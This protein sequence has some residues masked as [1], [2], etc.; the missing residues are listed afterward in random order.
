MWRSWARART[1]IT[2]RSLGPVRRVIRHFQYT[3]VYLLTSQSQ[4]KKLSEQE[5][6]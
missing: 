4:N 3:Q 1:K 5:I 6:K 2:M